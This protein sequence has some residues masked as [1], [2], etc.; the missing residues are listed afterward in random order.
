M[1]YLSIPHYLA[2][3][4]CTLRVVGFCQISILRP[5]ATYFNIQ[6]DIGLLVQ[7]LDVITALLLKYYAT[8]DW[9]LPVI[10]LT[11]GACLRARLDLLSLNRARPKS[12]IM[13]I[14]PIFKMFFSFK[15]R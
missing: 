7:R 3:P 14:S 9:G 2:I 15:S 5:A 11:V 12:E 10:L 6:S 8:W 1:I 4:D 13:K